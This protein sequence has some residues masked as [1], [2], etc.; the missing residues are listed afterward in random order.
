MLRIWLTIFSVAAIAFAGGNRDYRFSV[1]DEQ[2]RED[3]K[4]V[5]AENM[6]VEAADDSAYLHSEK[7]K[8]FK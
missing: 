6:C 1:P 4:I 2:F 5:D 8:F 7:I 3:A